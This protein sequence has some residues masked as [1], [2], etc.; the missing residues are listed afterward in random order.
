MDYAYLKPIKRRNIHNSNVSHRNVNF[1][2]GFWWPSWMYADLESCHK[3]PLDNKTEFVLGPPLDY[4]TRTFP[5][6]ENVKSTI[7]ILKSNDVHV[8]TF[9]I[10]MENHYFVV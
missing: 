8:S 9:S 7:F 6:S 4:E 2:D 10:K 3:V 1:P 5:G